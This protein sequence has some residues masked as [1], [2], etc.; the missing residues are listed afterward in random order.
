MAGSPG[1]RMSQERVGTIIGGYR[2][3]ALLG[4]GG[5]AAVYRAAR[6]A[7]GAR[8]VAAIKVLHPW[9]GADPRAKKRFLREA[10]VADR[11]RHPAIVRTLESGEDRSGAAYL[12]MELAEGETLEQR[13]EASG[14]RLPLD[15]VLRLAD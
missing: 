10:A 15:E 14:G 1:A 12:I 6:D 3:E 7:G 9:L 8:E 11:V 13:R 5:T 4:V 2:L